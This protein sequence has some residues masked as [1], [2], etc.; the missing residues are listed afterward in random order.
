MKVN[1]KC[2]LKIYQKYKPNTRTNLFDCYKIV[3]IMSEGMIIFLASNT[4]CQVSSQSKST[5]FFSVC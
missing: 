1:I 5:E 3:K 4:H 2:I